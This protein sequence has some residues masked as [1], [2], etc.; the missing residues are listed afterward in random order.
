MPGGFIL[1][2]RLQDKGGEMRE[3]VHPEKPPEPGLTWVIFIHGFRV[4]EAKALDQW[5]TLRSII[6]IRY[7]ET[8]V[9]A[10]VLLW[11][12][13]KSLLYPEMIPFAEKAGQKLGRYLENHPGSPAVLVGHSMGA[14]V[15]MEAA[16]RLLR[17]GSRLQGFVLLGAAVGVSQ[18]EED[19]R[20]DI[21][22]AEREAVGFSPGDGTLRRLF[23]PGE[24]AAAPF[25]EIGD[26]VGLKGHPESR[27][28]ER[29]KS[30]SNSHKYWKLAVSGELTRL[31]VS[32]PATGQ[33]PAAWTPAEHHAE[34]R[35]DI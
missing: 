35:D 33:Q 14:R 3:R 1:T 30:G 22:H 32:S 24:R 31:M 18:F 19:E 4:H 27:H 9:Q 12:S 28:W 17:R 7:D 2:L 21:T 8:R 29:K 10:G 13:D 5:Q 15:A 34:Q 20:Y 26:A 25:R 23:R 16:D 6:G 11:P